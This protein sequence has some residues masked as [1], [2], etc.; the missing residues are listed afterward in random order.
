MVNK[1]FLFALLR[2]SSPSGYETEALEV[3]NDYC[4]QFAK[5]EFMDAIG[6]S[7]YSV[8]TG[9]RKIMISGH[10]DEIGLQVQYIDDNGFIYFIK[11]GGIDPKTLLGANVFIITKHGKVQG[12]IGKKPIHVEARCDDEKSKA[13]PITSMKIDCGFENKT[14]AEEYISVGDPV[15]FATMP[16]Q[17]GINRVTSRGLDDKS[18]VYV[19]AEVLKLLSKADLKNVTVYGCAC[20]QEEVGG[21][22]AHIAAKRINPQFSIDYDVTFATDDDYV[23][24]KEWG[25]IKLGKGGAIAFGTDNNPRLTNFIK[26]IGDKYGIPYQTFSVPSNCTDTADIKKASFNCYTSLLSVPNRNMHTPVEVCDYR[27]L[28]A[29]VE[30]TVMTILAIENGEL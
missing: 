4:S 3:F 10:I 29:L 12:V 9:G 21:L 26:S 28:D 6:N 7:C 5:H 25:D 30:L 1:D 24:P 2:A 16:S 11:D 27:D 14:D 19:T 22:G 15:I 17:L 13:T 8:G 23:S 18:G 20:P